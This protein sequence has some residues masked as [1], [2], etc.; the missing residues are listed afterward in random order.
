MELK[1]NKTKNND[2]DLVKV[3]AV[4]KINAML[5]LYVWNFLLL[6]KSLQGLTMPKVSAPY[7][8]SVCPSDSVR[9]FVESYI[10]CSI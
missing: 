4:P 3:L 2:I 10:M 6:I 8:L 7:G 1:K 9:Y 5:F